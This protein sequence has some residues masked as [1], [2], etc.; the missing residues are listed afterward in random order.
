[1]PVEH[2]YPVLTQ[3]QKK[4]CMDEADKPTS[5]LPRHWHVVICGHTEELTEVQDG[6]GDS[7]KYNVSDACPVR[8][9]GWQTNIAPALQEQMRYSIT[10]VPRGKRTG[11][12]KHTGQDTSWFS[13]E[14]IKGFLNK[15]VF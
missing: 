4:C 7:H 6:T 13:L 9:T 8:V 5:F 1:M 14:G 12:Q 10:N 3:S 15:V 11:R 2:L